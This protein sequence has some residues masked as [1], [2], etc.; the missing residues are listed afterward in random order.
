M[1][2]KCKD[3]RAYYAKVTR[4]MVEIISEALKY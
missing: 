4:N 3:L 2:G 1:L